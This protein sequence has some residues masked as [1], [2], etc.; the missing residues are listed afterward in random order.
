MSE[1]EPL[2]SIG[3]AARHVGVSIDTLRRWADAGHVSVTRTPTGQRRFRLA[4]IEAAFK[5]PS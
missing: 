4:D 5:G 2:V 1:S 3:E